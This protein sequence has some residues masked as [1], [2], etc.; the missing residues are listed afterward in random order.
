MVLPTLNLIVPASRIVPP[1]DGEA[2]LVALYE[3]A[4]GALR[5]NMIATVDGGAWGPDHVS[6][7]INDDADWRVFRVQRALADVVVVGAGTARAEQYTQLG[8]PDG[9]AHLRAAPLELALVTRSGDVPPL[10]V[11]ADRL[12][13]VI[14]GARGAAAAQAALP[15]DRVIVVPA[16]GRDGDG[17]DEDRDVDRGDVDLAAGLSALA[18][19]GLRRVLCEG[20]PHLLADLLAAG[21]VDELCVTTSPRLVGPG[22]S[23]IVAGEGPASGASAAPA[24]ARLAHLL[25]EPAAGT[26]LARW[27]LRAGDDGSATGEAGG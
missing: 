12:P 26:L 24:G 19:L 18:A 8:R 25:H 10:L 22:P 7:S 20:G 16:T 6:G 23:R 4:P 5:A 3:H 11:Q 1:D 13:Y 2:D 17:G 21:L 27:L 14:T 15:A 9:L